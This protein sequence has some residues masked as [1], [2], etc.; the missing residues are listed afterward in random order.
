MADITPKQFKSDWDAGQ[1]PFL[2]DVREQNE[3]DTGNLSPYGAVHIPMNEVPQHLDQI[4]KD[5]RVVCQCRSGGRS[6]RVVAFL[7]S[8]GY[9]QVENLTGGI[10][11]WAQEVDPSM[12]T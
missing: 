2:L 6:G 12:P 9:T 7:E 1:R 4:P 10:L 3:W 11:R 8:Q 5:R